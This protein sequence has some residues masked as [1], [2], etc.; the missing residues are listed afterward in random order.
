MAFQSLWVENY[1]WH[2]MFITV[3]TMLKTF[4]E[5]VKQIKFLSLAPDMTSRLTILPEIND[6]IM[7]TDMCQTF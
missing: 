7:I 5:G 4:Y 6:K 2:L 1:I 3:G